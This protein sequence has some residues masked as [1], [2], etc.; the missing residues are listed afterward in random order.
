[1]MLDT[2][3][4]PESDATIEEA[5]RIIRCGG[6]IGFLTDTLYG[7]GCDPLDERAVARVAELKERDADKPILVVI[8]DANESLRFI[9]RKSKLF[10]RLS[11]EFWGGALTIIEIAKP[12]LPTPLVSRSGTIGLRLP[13]DVRVRRL[14]EAC[15]GA[16]T[17]TS[18][19]PTSQPPAMTALEVYDY[20]RDKL[21]LIV[22]SGA[23]GSPLPSTIVD[24]TKD[25]PRLIREGA[26]DRVTLERV[27][28]LAK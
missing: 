5:A 1:M 16:L 20:F 12:D 15:S 19:N 22:D 8:S 2:I 18:A 28:M 3:V 7:I 25:P 17:A 10:S 27:V 21:D 26:L 9:A 14:I 11:E 13:G 6:V 23:A 4:Q 24:V